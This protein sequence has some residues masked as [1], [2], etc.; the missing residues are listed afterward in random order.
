MAILTPTRAIVFCSCALLCSAAEP[1]RWRGLILDQTT[2]QQAIQ[3]LGTPQ[4]D[5]TADIDKQARNKMFGNSGVFFLKPRRADVVRILR[6]DSLEDFQAVSLVFKGDALVLIHLMPS[7]ANRIEAKDFEALYDTV[8]F[9]VVYTDNDFW[10][11]DYLVDQATRTPENLS[12]R[13]LDTRRKKGEC[14]QRRY[15]NSQ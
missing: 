4:K 14:P 5:A 7:K 12:R 8:T 2:P 9:R 1:D 10:K 6:Y 11:Q 15:W 13:I 3:T